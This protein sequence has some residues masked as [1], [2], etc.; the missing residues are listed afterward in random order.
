MTTTTQLRRRRPKTD[1]RPPATI[2]IF[3]SQSLSKGSLFSTAL[4][5]TTATLR[6]YFSIAEDPTAFC[7]A[8]DESGTNWATIDT[9]A[10][11]KI[12]HNGSE[13][14]LTTTRE[15]KGIRHEI[16]ITD[17]L[18]VQRFSS[19]FAGCEKILGDSPVAL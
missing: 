3:S 1:H 8:Q 2:I 4:S 9:K 6:N 19:I 15:D 13:R 10:D 17:N 14:F 16:R 12:Q 5:P 7:S 18:L 11:S